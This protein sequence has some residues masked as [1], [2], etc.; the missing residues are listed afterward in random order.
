MRVPVPANL[1]VGC[2]FD[3]AFK[4]RETTLDE[5]YRAIDEARG[6]VAACEAR[7]VELVS[8]IEGP[9]DE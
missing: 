6:V 8:I 2:F 4:V 5:V 3:P 1:K 7:R 9:H